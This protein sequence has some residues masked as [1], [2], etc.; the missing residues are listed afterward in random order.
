MRQ[1]DISHVVGSKGEFQAVF[2]HLTGTEQGARVV[3]EDVDA[4]FCRGNLGRDPLHLDKPREISIVDAVQDAGCA[5]AQPCQHRLT[6]DLVAG[7]HYQ[8][9]AHAGQPLR[10]D[11][12][13]P[14]G[15]TGNDDNLPMHGAS[16]RC[17]V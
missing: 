17:P 12:P 8:A 9:R 2:G 6:T 15:R 1:H 7:H 14:G 5:L 3:D 4:R 13:D 16:S 11:L 10:R